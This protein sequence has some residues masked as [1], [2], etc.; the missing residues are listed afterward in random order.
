MDNCKNC[1]SHN[2]HQPD[3]KQARVEVIH[4][5]ASVQHE[6]EHEHL[7]I[8]ID[9]YADLIAAATRLQIVKRWA[10]AHSICSR[11]DFCE[12]RLLLGIE[13]ENER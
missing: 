1:N 9:E 11:I 8:G 2:G 7:R 12:L 4:V 3:P 13:E 6:D 5:E 10:Q